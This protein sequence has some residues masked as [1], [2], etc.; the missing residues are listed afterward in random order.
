MRKFRTP[1]LPV[2]AVGTIV[3]SLFLMLQLPWLTKIVFL[4]WMAIGLVIYFA[5]GRRNSKQGQLELP[6]ID[7]RA[8]IWIVALATILAA[9]PSE[10]SAGTFG[11]G[12]ARFHATHYAP[13]RFVDSV[14]RLHFDV[15][16]GVVYGDEIATVTAKRSGTRDLPFN[17]VGI[18][19]TRVTVN[20]RACAFALDPAR[21][22]ITVR[23]PA[24]TA[25]GTQLPVEFV[26]RA[27]PQR[28]IFFVRPDAAYPHIA[29]EIWT[30]G[31]PT[32]NRRW[33]PTWDQPNEKTPSEL[34]VTVPRGWTVVG[35]GYL[36]AH[37]YMR[38]TDT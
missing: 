38:A 24:P 3:G 4:S 20:G 15:A 8:R 2:F 1:A 23:L 16:V 11:N 33:F 34:I 26:Y 35:N 5:Y 17:S 21:E 29:P 30:Q 36:R 22:L 19:Y 7:C 14:I 28:G 37:T 27:Q 9:A 32:D 18:A 12:L 25:A 10:S 31:E 13:Y 6:P